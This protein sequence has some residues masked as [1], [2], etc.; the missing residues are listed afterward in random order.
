MVAVK[1]S[2]LQYLR[3]AG[4]TAAPGT[5]ANIRTHTA[6]VVHVPV[7]VVSEANVREHWGAKYRR[8]KNQKAMVIASLASLGL[9][10]ADRAG[11]FAN[12]ATVT[13]VRRGGRAM[14]THDNLPRACKAV[15]DATSTW[16]GK[17]DAEITWHYEQRAK[18]RKDA[19]GLTL[20]IEPR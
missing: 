10:P 18:G 1:V 19:A 8:A 20:I 17:D 15:V 2:Q 13:V 14:D 5:T 3:A 4:S 11:I 9:S 12:G 16:I 7:K 6:W